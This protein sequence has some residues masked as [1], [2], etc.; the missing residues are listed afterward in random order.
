MKA[1]RKRAVVAAAIGLVAAVTAV[2]V[3]S[4]ATAS[5]RGSDL[6]G[7]VVTRP[8]VTRPVQG[9]DL[10]GPVVTHPV[11]GSVSYAAGEMCSFPARADF[12]VSDLT[13]KTWYDRAGDPVF[14]TES[15]P[16]IMRATNLATG[17]SV[18]RDVS[19][20]GIATYPDADSF[21]LSGNDWSAGFHTTDRPVHNAWIVA[22][23]YMSVKVTTAPDGTT[24]RTLLALHGP[25][26]NLCDTLS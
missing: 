14:S 6:T 1:L 26:E 23:G 9:A 8:V 20:S 21:I 24:S 13:E 5:T 17:R 16:L 15:G 10:T 4:S 2:A 12:P 11:Q 25:H 7:P 22:Y 3:P 19:G 18:L